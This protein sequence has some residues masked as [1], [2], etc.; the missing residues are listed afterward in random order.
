[1]H[2]AWNTRTVCLAL[3][4]GGCAKSTAKETPAPAPSAAIE[5]GVA[6]ASAPKTQLCT[7]GLHRRG[8]HWKIACNVCRC[9]ADGAILCSE[10]DC[11]ERTSPRDA[12]RTD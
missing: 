9:G 10:Y 1:M 6:P 4:L 7:D 3:L 5:A 8:D 11:A 12:S 2:P